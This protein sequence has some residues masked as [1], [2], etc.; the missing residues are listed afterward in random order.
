MYKTSDGKIHNTIEE[1]RNHAYAALTEEYTKLI[2]EAVGGLP[3]LPTM[4]GTFQQ[5]N[6]TIQKL[7]G[8]IA[9]SVKK[10]SATKQRGRPK[11]TGPVKPIISIVEV[12]P[13][14]EPVRKR[15]R[16]PGT[17]LVKKDKTVEA[18]VVTDAPVK[19]RG[20]P[21]KAAAVNTQITDAVTAAAPAPVVVAA[22]RRGRP[23]KV[24][25]EET[26]SSD[27]EQ[28]AKRRGRPPK[29]AVQQEVT[30][31]AIKVVPPIPV[32][33]AIANSVPNL[34]VSFAPPIS[35]APMTPPPA[36]P[37]GAPSFPLA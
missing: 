25:T 4:Y 10:P 7:A 22:K 29:A 28:P 1:A 12:T 9:A 35:P 30:Q 3:Y 18:A 33:S 11:G 32:A 31:T 23:A 27:V 2:F 26:I 34:P 37:P 16:K 5:H 8:V 36:F 17:K 20:R 21:A 15:G 13:A 6:E 14:G 24:K 19:R